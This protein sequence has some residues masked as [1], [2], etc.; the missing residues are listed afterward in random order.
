MCAIAIDHYSLV[1]PRR[2]ELAVN[3]SGSATLNAERWRD[4]TSTFGMCVTG[5]ERAD[6]ERL[7]EC[8]D[9]ESLDRSRVTRARINLSGGPEV[10]GWAKVPIVA[11]KEDEMW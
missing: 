8:R 2:E 10:N 5:P 1:E 11:C 3:V 7:P 4:E 6:G 9:A